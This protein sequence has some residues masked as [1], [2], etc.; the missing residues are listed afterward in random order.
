VL[1]G[2]PGSSG[3]AFSRTILLNR[4]AATFVDASEAYA[5]GS[6]TF[7]QPGDLDRD[8]I[9][10]LVGVNG[11]AIVV[12]RG[13]KKLDRAVF[14]TTAD[15]PARLVNLS[16]LT[17]LASRDDSFTVGYVASG[18]SAT[19][20]K[21]LV[22]RAAGPSLAA[23]GV[24]G[25]LDAP[26]LEI[27]AGPAKTGENDDWGGAEATTAAMAAVGAFGYAGPTS[28]DAAQVASVTSTDNSVKVTAGAAS[29]TG[30]GAVIAEVYDATPA[31][32]RT[33]AT[34]RLINFSV[35]KQISAGGSLT[36]GFVIG[37]NTAKAVLIRVVGPGLATVGLTSGTLG[38]PQLTLYNGRSEKIAVNDDWGA[39]PV[40][41]A[42][43][44]RV[45]AFSVGTAAT[46][47]AMLQIELTPGSYTA[48]ATG[49][50]NT[51]G[52]AIVEVYELP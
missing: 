36:L 4:G 51:S 35:A 40:L 2:A 42:A 16:V 48:T 7:L 9:V 33:A 27:Y 18:A 52:F 29:A 30:A 6:V 38:D 47:D 41:I 19:N 37:G 31:G 11:N 1:Q 43:G 45:G 17:S 39:T 34:P 44:A 10:D 23:F 8:G 22:I 20:P 49:N 13:L 26:K 5:G 14:Q 21:S 32:A 28:R 12:S 15:D 50:A 46:K 25:T 24:P 3:A